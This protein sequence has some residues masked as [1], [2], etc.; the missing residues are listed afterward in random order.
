MGSYGVHDVLDLTLWLCSGISYSSHFEFLQFHLN[1]VVLN[2]TSVEGIWAIW[3]VKFYKRIYGNY[4]SHIEILKIT[5][6][7]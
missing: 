4:G 1:Y 5:S 3:I 7:R 2:S 6:S